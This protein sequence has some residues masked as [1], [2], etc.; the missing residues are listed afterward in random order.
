[1]LDFTG[2]FL[3]ILQI[4]VDAAVSNNGVWI[5]PTISNPVKFGLGNI[6]MGFDIIFMVQHFILYKNAADK[7]K[8]EEEGSRE[9]YLPLNTPVDF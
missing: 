5:A 1:M 9:E 2:G 3:S 6:S 4:F 8:E 7:V